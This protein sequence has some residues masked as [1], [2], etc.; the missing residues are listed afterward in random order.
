[1]NQERNN[2]I[3]SLSV[4]SQ[5]GCSQVLSPPEREFYVWPFAAKSILC[6]RLYTELEHEG[7]T[8]ETSLSAYDLS[9]SED[10]VAAE[11]VTRAVSNVTSQSG[12]KI[13]RIFKVPTSENTFTEV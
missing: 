11:D 8:I 12:T 10:C 2:L 3:V 1:M 7:F 13:V 9:V 4:V 6:D 5:D